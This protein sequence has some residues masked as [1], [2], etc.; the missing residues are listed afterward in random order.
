MWAPH[1]DALDSRYAL[2][3]LVPAHTIVGRGI[4]LW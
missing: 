4:A 2:M 3:G 1:L